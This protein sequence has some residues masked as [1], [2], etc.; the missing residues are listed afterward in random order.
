MAGPE[1]ESVCRSLSEEKLVMD[2]TVLFLGRTI[3]V[4]HH[5]I[6]HEIQ[7]HVILGRAS[8]PLERICFSRV[9]QKTGPRVRLTQG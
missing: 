9:L 3:P 8:S 6:S 1:K 5:G 2:E 7:Y 4:S